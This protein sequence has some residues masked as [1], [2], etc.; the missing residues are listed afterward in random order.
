VMNN[1]DSQDPN[2]NERK[3]SFVFYPDLKPEAF[4][5]SRYGQP[6]DTPSEMTRYVHD[7]NGQVFYCTDRLSF[8]ANLSLRS[9]EHAAA[10]PNSQESKNHFTVQGK[11]RDDKWSLTPHFAE[12]G[13]ISGFFVDQGEKL[14]AA[15]V[16]TPV[17]FNTWV[18]VND[19]EDV[20][21][22][23]I[24]YD[25]RIKVEYNGKVGQLDSY[26]TFDGT[27]AVEGLARFDEPATWQGR[28]V[29]QVTTDANGKVSDEAS[30]DVLCTK[31]G[32]DLF[33]NSPLQM[34]YGSENLLIEGSGE[35]Y[36]AILDRFETVENDSVE[37]LRNHINCARHFRLDWSK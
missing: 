16:P 25:P 27:G 24:G 2:Y 4:Y 30:S 31:F 29:R 13:R 10:R 6:K 21:R 23:I 28:R 15:G 33:P 7:A 3:F 11:L 12:N 5:V 18:D 35:V 34:N 9:Y 19:N 26:V 14:R 1:P 22:G 37:V 17:A 8:H 36:N 32:Y 20:V